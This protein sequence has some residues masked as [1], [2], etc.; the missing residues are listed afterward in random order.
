MAY[1]V[2]WIL[3]LAMVLAS[4]ALFDTKS[5]VAHIAGYCLLLIP[6]LVILTGVLLA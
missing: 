4:L 5:R 6:V 3:L 1:G 2:V